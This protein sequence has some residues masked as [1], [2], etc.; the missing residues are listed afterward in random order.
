VTALRIV[1]EADGGSRGNP[2]PAGYG[3]LVR[4][5]ETGELLSEM[6]EGI[7]V[8][9]NNVAEYRGL[10][11][12]LQAAVDLG[13]EDVEVRMDSKLVV[14]QMSG[15]WKVKHP[16]MRVLARQAAGLIQ[17][18][19]AVHFTHIPR[20]LN[21][22]ADRLANQAMDDQGAGRLWQRRDAAPSGEAAPPRNS[23][24]GW[25]TPG[26]PATVAMLLRHG[27]TALSAE[28]RFSGRGDVA[29]TEHG[30]T[31]AAAVARRLSGAGIDAIVSSPLRRAQQTAAAV[32]AEVGVDVAVDDGFV[33]T[34]FGAWEGSSLREVAATAPDVVRAWLDNPNV[35]P[36]G[37]ESMS[38]T[39]IRVAA[40]RERVVAA[41]P[42]KTVLVVT[43]VTP[44]KL[45]LRDA[46]GAP[47]DAV[48]RMHLDL[49]SLSVVDWH[50]RSASVVRLV[51]DTGHLGE[52]VTAQRR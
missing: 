31:Q 24:Y 22:H 50:D 27:Q 15:R 25:S 36:P 8:A 12:G 48:F 35:A 10:I 39:A 2:G 28:K 38:A 47:F 37:G 16:D 52:L 21:S 26:E 29:L 43:H 23:L 19:P 5:A 46:L 6:A 49:T 17:T 14:E 51:N 18:L 40:A 11:A 30:E 42:G 44:I 32:A 41:Y 45:L 3:A 1:V 34:D 33:E 7:G 20:E 4:D 13:A 9:S